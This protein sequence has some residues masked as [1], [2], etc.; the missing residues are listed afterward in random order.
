M[1]ARALVGEARALYFPTDRF[2]PSYTRSKS[3]GNLSGTSSRQHREEHRRSIPCR[4]KFPGRRISSAE[5]RNE[6]HEAQY[7]A[8]VSAAD[9]ENERLDRAGGPGRILLR[10]TGTGRAHPAL[11]PDR[12]GNIKSLCDLTQAQYDTGVGDQYLGGGGARP[13]CRSAQSSLTNLGILRAQYEHAIAVLLGKA[14]VGFLSYRRTPSPR[15]RPPIPDWH[16]LSTCYSAGRTC[17]G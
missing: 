7:T 9:L 13:L 17:R 2:G 6:V 16:A 14:G 4:W 3:S 8:Q 1:E 12:R 10:D 5:I 11:Y 15:R